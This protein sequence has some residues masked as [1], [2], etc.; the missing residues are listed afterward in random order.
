MHNYTSNISICIPTQHR[1]SHGRTIYVC[2]MSVRPWTYHGCPIDVRLRISSDVRQKTSFGRPKHS[3]FSSDIYRQNMNVHCMSYVGRPLD[4]RHRIFNES[5]SHPF[6][7]STSVFD[8]STI[9][10]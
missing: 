1:T 8:I 3:R 6:Y 9:F 2:F 10:F 5:K 4:I 7:V